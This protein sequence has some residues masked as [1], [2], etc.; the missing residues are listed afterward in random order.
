M[1][2]IDYFTRNKLSKSP[3]LGFFNDPKIDFFS[4]KEG[5]EKHRKKLRFGVSVEVA[6]ATNKKVIEIK[7]SRLKD[8]ECR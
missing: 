2:I 6:P 4:T 3:L 7:G 8:M 5:E 1:Q